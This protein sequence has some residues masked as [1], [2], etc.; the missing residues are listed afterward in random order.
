[1]MG[2]DP[3]DILLHAGE[4]LVIAHRGASVAAPENTMESFQRAV[5]LGADAIE[6]D[7]RITA[8]GEI[9]VVHDPTLDRTAGIRGVVQSM[10]A[11]QLREADAGAG[12]TPDGGLSYP[13]RGRGVRVPLLAEVLEAFP[14]TPLLVEVKTVGAMRALEQLVRR[15]GA[16][17]RVVPA[18]EHHGA[19]VAFRDAPFRCG[20]SRRDIARLYFG[21][22][23]RAPL[24]QHGRYGLLAVPYRWHGLEVPTPGFVSAAQDVGA[25]VHVWTVDEPADARRLWERGVSGIVT[26]D[27]AAMVAELQR[28]RSQSG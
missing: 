5:E 4:P 9:V 26:N 15:H 10:T 17:G 14:E 7:V 11:R 2:S 16:A 8:D 27:P 23:L 13:F 12:F 6:M 21:S 1:M 28:M 22:L 3:A 18:S 20:A 19:L 25:A 24:P